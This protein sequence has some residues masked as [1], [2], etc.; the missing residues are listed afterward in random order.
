MRG[1]GTKSK[2]EVT[3]MSWD[4]M[5][6]IEKG[7]EDETLQRILEVIRTEMD[8]LSEEK[9][10]S[11]IYDT[12]DT[13]IYIR[14]DNIEL[15]HAVAHIL[16]SNFQSDSEDMEIGEFYVGIRGKLRRTLY[17]DPTDEDSNI[18]K[19][20]EDD[21]EFEAKV[22]DDDIFILFE[23]PEQDVRIRIYFEVMFNKYGWLIRVESIEI[24]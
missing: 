24:L 20:I 17:I 23:E 21:E 18:I 14:V 3:L 15:A 19:F 8:L 22:Y 2:K 7:N 11:S 9:I 12:E 6:I 13:K 10:E 1:F 5:I 16:T 4:S